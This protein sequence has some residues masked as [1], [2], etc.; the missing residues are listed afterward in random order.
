LKNDSER[1]SFAVLPAAHPIHS[2][3]IG[4]ATFKGGA[5]QESC[6]FVISARGEEIAFEP[7][8]NAHRFLSIPKDLYQRVN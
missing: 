5:N 7:R 3:A 6:L 8:R 2:R 4:P 1:T